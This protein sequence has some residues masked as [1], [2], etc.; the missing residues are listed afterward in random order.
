MIIDRF[1]A[2]VSIVHNNLLKTEKQLLPF[3]FSFLFHFLS[4]KKK[5]RN[6]K[7]YIKKK[8]H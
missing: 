3:L 8:N 5:M 4:K 7:K 6:K 2:L 1:S